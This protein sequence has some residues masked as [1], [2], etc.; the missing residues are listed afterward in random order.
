MENLTVVFWEDEPQF[1]VR[2]PDGNYH[3]AAIALENKLDKLLLEIKVELGDDW[4]CHDLHKSVQCAGLKTSNY[5][6]IQECYWRYDAV[7]RKFTHEQLEAAKE[8]AGKITDKQLE[9]ARKATGNDELSE[10]DVLQAFQ[11]IDDYKNIE[12][13]R[14]TLREDLI[15]FSAQHGRGVTLAD[16]I[17]ACRIALAVQGQYKGE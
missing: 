16:R 6:P 3:E 13:V 2:N 15:V 8:A 11:R 17:D 7:D 12:E 5:I 14:E 4:D 9:A 10:D 1:A